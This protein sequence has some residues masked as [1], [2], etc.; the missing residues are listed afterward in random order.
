MKDILGNALLD[1]YNGIAQK[2][3]IT[4]TNIS[5]EDTL[6][7]DYFFREFPMM[8]RLEQ[9]ALDMA[10]GAILDVG[11]GAGSHSLYL[12]DKDHR[13][14]AIDVSKKAIE[15]CRKRGVANAQVLDILN[16]TESFDTILLLMNGTGIFQKLDQVSKYL[17]HLKSLLNEGGQILL[18][19]SDILYMYEDED[20]GYWHDLNANYYGE[21]DY[22]ISYNGEEETPMKWL[23]LDFNTLR[24]IAES[25]GLN[26]Q[27]VIEGENNDYLA[28]LTVGV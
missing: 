9:L 6:P 17:K 13:V 3:I 22:F 20:G 19:S 1:H 27:L 12:Q 11:C 4:W 8:K 26:C 16:E 18:D 5:V 24:E 15:V 2:D 28:R 7:I 23:Y 14:K 25:S 21:L 10:T